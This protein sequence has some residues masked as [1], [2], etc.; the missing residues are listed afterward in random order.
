MI[1]YLS[2]RGLLEQRGGGK[3]VHPYL[4]FLMLIKLNNRVKEVNFI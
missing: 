2:I 3:G 1:D 4:S